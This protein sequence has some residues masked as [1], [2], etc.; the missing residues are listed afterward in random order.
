M[1]ELESLIRVI[2][3]KSYLEYMGK[4]PF[5]QLGAA[6]RVYLGASLLPEMMVEENAYTEDQIKFRSIAA[7]AGTRFSPTQ[8]KSGDLYG[9]FEVRLAEMDIAREMTGREY[10]TLLRM[11]AGSSNPSMQSIASVVDWAE[12]T[13]NRAII[14]RAEA[15]RWEAIVDAA[16]VRGGDNAYTET[17]TYDDP[18]NHRTAQSAA[19][20]TNTTDIFAQI[21][22]KVDLLADKG[23]T[24]SRMITSRNVFNKMA[25]NAITRTRTSRIAIDATGQL[26]G[27]PGKATF[28]ALNSALAE[29]G[30]PPIELYD[31]RYRT[32]TT[33]QRFLPN[34][35]FVFI[36]ETG[37]DQ[38]ID[39]PDAD[40]RIPLPNTLGYYAVGRA[41]GQSSPGK[42]IRLEAK[43]DKPP[44]IEGEAWMTGLPVIQE[45]EAIAVIHSIT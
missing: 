42:V 11:L 12:V 33:S 21:F 16:I 27:A 30:L 15:D 44:R 9:A 39:L 41:A 2:K 20:S 35:V 38:T 32:Q 3:E 17:V 28:N 10:D 6:N 4:N 8:K 18:A 40:Q 43:F 45:P 14:E 25:N 29:D 36:A 23:L 7:N 22:T 31:L 19:W 13:L 1:S 24:V 26:S 37:R 34:D 5:A